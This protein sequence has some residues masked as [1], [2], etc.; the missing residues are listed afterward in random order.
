MK[1]EKLSTEDL[2]KALKP[3]FDPILKE[4]LPDWARGL[5]SELR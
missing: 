5:L 4:G 1:R 2:A 3:L